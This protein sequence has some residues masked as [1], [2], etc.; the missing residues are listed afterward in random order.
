MA[1]KDDNRLMDLQRQLAEVS[2]QLVNMGGDVN[3][4]LK[5]IDT[6]VLPG[7]RSLERW[8]ATINERSSRDR[9]EIEDIKKALERQ[10]AETAELKSDFK[11]ARQSAQTL[12]VAVVSVP[13]L[14]SVISFF[15]SAY[16]PK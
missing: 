11:A 5:T 15:V 16:R 7:I 13:V 12:W 3:R 4:V 8:Q 6:E 10:A 9:T 1:E 14:V 2:A